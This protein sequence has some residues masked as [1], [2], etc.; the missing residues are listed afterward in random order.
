MKL[1]YVDKRENYMI[2]L[3]ERTLFE[4]CH[5]YLIEFALDRF[6][7]CKS[8]PDLVCKKITLQNVDECTGIAF[9]VNRMKA[10]LTHQ[11]DK[12]DGFLYYTKDTGETVGCIWVMYRGGNEFQY[13]V[14]NVEAFGFDFGIRGKFRGRGIIVWMIHELLL[15]LQKK[16]IRTLYASVR[17]NNKSAIKAYTKAGMKI[18]REK[19][20]FRI[21]GI[22]IP[23][24]IV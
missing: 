1:L 12:V 9:N 4:Y 23:Y 11:P 7:K 17:T 3:M 13:R 2:R 22:R 10:Y 24:P 6:E 8:Y 18:V 14:R 19:R 16:G 15:Y 5:H 20:F 21:V